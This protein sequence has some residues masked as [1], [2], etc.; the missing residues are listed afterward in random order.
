[1]LFLQIDETIKAG[2]DALNSGQ[3]WLI[4]IKSMA[5]DYAPKL[6][7]AVLVYL[8][9]QWIIGRIGR[10]SRKVLSTRNFDISLQ[11]FLLSL[12]KVTLSILLFLAIAGMVGVDITG[13]AAI[14][15]GAGIAIGAA[16]NGSLGNL[17]GGVMLMIFKPFKV[18]DMIEAQGSIGIVQ[19]IGIF[20]TTIL[21]P[22]NKTVILPN[23]ALSTGVITNYT[24]H[25]NLRVDLVMAVAL[26][27]DIDTARRIASE[28]MLQHPKVLKAPAPEVSVLKV[29]DGM[30]SLAIRPYTTQADYWDVY[31]GVQELVKKAFDANGVA[32]PIPTRILI[33]KQ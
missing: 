33:N 12:I 26:D 23:G 8:I 3:V 13:F 22:E 18:H 11:K 29:G 14:L 9:G 17:A 15:A 10:L 30:T 28:A 4:K 32:G 16:L 6:I 24:T 21:S 2:A 25:G 20:N 5:I 7:G 19:E 27:V 31:F 1:M